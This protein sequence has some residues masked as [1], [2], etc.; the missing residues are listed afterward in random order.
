MALGV[1]EVIVPVAILI[2]CALI[3]IGFR[4]MR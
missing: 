1:G 4:R 3:V 2:I